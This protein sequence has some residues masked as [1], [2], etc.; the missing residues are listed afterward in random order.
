MP[1]MEL[2]RQSPCSSISLLGVA[3]VGNIVLV[4]VGSVIGVD[5][6]VITIRI[7]IDPTDSDYEEE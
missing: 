7:N 2:C 3:G 6:F 4:D 5:S 1:V